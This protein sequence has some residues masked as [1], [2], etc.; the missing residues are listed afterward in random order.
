M[1]IKKIPENIAVSARDVTK[2][3][4][5]YHRQVDRL[6]E[7]ITRRDYGVNRYSVRDISFEI[8]KGEVVGIIGKNGAGKSTLLKMIAG[9]LQPTS[10]S[11]AVKGNVAAILEL[12]TGFH[13]DIS[14]RENVIMGGLCLGM[15]RKHIEKEMQRII[16]F[17]E[18]EDV[19]DEPFGTYSSGMQARLTF[20]TAVTVNPDVLIIDEALSVGDNRFQLKSF[21][22]IRQFRDEGKTILLVT[23]SMDSVTS[24]CDR[25]ILIDKGKMLADGDPAWV[26]SLYHNLQFGTVEEKS[27][28]R[29]KENNAKNEE[30][31]GEKVEL[32]SV[33]DANSHSP[34]DE[35]FELATPE[36]FPFAH[37]DSDLIE[38]QAR[39][40]Y[41]YGDQRATI[42]GIALVD[43]SALSARRDV[44][45]GD[46]VQCVIDVTTNVDAPKLF[47]GVLIRDPKGEIAFGTDTS[48]G[49]PH[50]AAVLENVKAGQSFRV[51]TGIKVW[52]APG[53]YFLGGALTVEEGKQS[54]MWFDSFE[55]RVLGPSI[56]HTNS[57]A[58][59]QPDVT[60]LPVAG[61]YSL[62][63]GKS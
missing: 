34:C 55:F 16:D 5:S 46:H 43:S 25:A 1:I 2:S 63:E 39:K 11:I 47:V 29:K 23:H 13:P 32:I 56:Q 35:T 57:R 52:L 14:G 62:P 53:T 45:V 7:W 27:F 30:K 49:Q 20:A 18:L 21:N 17:S 37:S 26:T 40:G 15:S 22:R 12:G 60:V 42:S 54:D 48:L 28:D 38:D 24:F 50:N 3:F 19:I 6:R 31:L 10:G 36:I 41:R 58:F 44:V 61:K 4:R 8:A 33:T 51:V 9:V 59:L